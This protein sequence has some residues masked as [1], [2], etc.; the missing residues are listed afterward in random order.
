MI[1][2][3]YSDVAIS[4]IMAEFMEVEKQPGWLCSF[5]ECLIGGKPRV[6]KAFMPGAALPCGTDVMDAIWDYLRE[7]KTD[8]N[9]LVSHQEAMIALLELKEKQDKEKAN[10]D[11]PVQATPAKNEH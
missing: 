3:N 6:F 4:H 2:Y 8:I 10:A 7:Q 9:I 1:Y 11:V 5:S